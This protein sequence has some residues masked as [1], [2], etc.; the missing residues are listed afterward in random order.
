MIGCWLFVV[1]CVFVTLL[2]F[3]VL[4]FVCYIVV[5]CCFLFVC[6]IVVCSFLVSSFVAV[7]CFVVRF[8][9]VSAYNNH[10]NNNG[11]DVCLC[12]NQQ[13]SRPTVDQEATNR[14]TNKRLHCVVV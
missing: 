2:L 13:P 6:Y 5:V 14:P 7:C 1:C 9:F 11:H 8:L 3:G 12:Y 10:C 4:L